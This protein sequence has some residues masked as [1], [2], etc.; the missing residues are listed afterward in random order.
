MSL[1]IVKCNR[2]P[3]K[4]YKRDICDPTALDYKNK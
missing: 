3:I 4:F 1:K 2:Y